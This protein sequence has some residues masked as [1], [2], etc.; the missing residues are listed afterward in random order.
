MTTKELQ[1]NLQLACS[2]LLMSVVRADDVID[3][4]ELHMTQEIISDFFDLSEEESLEMINSAGKLLQESTD[5]FQFG[6]ILNA[7]LDY[8]QK[9]DFILSVFEVA[10]ADNKLH[11]LEQHAIRKIA[12]ILHI[13][14]QDLIAAKL[15]IQ[16]YL[17]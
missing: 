17:E 16:K 6:V 7:E 11:H 15:E 1:G 5:I 8:Q 10:F 4:D 12:D 13:E 3:D 2:A 9:I 14:H